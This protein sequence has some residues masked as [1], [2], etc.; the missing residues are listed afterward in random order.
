MII[1]YDIVYPSVIGQYTLGYLKTGPP[2]FK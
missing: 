1:P 2:Y